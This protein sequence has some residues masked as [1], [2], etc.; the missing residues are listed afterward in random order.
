MPVCSRNDRG[1][2]IRGQKDLLGVR[3]G[4]SP[5]IGMDL[6]GPE[7]IV[8][9]RVFQGRGSH[10]LKF[11]MAHRAGKHRMVIQSVWARRTFC[12]SA[13]KIDRNR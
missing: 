1:R 8:S 4:N 3:D 11:T 13:I 5:P 7:R 9:D 2:F 12:F 10:A 6:K